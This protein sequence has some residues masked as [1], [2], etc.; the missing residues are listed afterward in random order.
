MRK[1]YIVN[2]KI[3]VKFLILFVPL[4][5]INRSNKELNEKLRFFVDPQNKKQQQNKIY[6]RKLIT[7]NSAFPQKTEIFSF[8]G[9]TKTILSFH[10]SCISHFT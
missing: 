4:K 6:Q 1:L 9:I 5:Y 3:R 2:G 7:S 10:Y 8:F